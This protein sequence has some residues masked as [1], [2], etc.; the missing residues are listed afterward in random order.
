M[1]SFHRFITAALLPALLSV[2]NMHE[3][4]SQIVVGI[5]V[6]PSIIHNRIRNVPPGY[7]IGNAG[8]SLR[9]SAGIFIDYR[10]ADR[11]T[12]FG[13]GIIYRPKVLKY[14]AYLPEEPDLLE[15]MHRLQ[16]LEV[17]LLLKL[18]TDEFALDK[19]FYTEC[20]L[21]PAILIHQEQTQ[22]EYPLITGF[23][24]VDLALHLG[25]GAEFQLGP[26][27]LFQ[28]GLSYS[29]GLINIAKS[30][31]LNAG[32]IFKNSMVSLDIG[33]RY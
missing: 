25:A 5:K 2:L 4:C 1:P 22:L 8:L 9:P 31:V 18:Y 13:T 17:P 20:G 3:A 12:A 7:D 14:R 27:T 21:V 29:R 26:R 15:K 24:P 28:L 10:Q 32:L 16:Y 6:S 23:R 11:H 19:R 33:L 30:D